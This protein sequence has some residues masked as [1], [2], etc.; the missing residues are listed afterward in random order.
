[1][2][3]NLGVT[4]KWLSQVE[5]GKQLGRI[6]QVLRLAVWLG[7]EITARLPDTGS[8]VTITTEY[9]DIDRMVE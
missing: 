3:K 6:G 8:V 9:P 5:Q 2:A 1:V 4:Q 7:L